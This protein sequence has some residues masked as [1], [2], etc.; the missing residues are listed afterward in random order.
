MTGSKILQQYKLN[1]DFKIKTKITGLYSTSKYIFDEL[2]THIYQNAYWELD[3]GYEAKLENITHCTK[4]IKHGLELVV[5]YHNMM[6]VTYPD[7]ANEFLN[8]KL[9]IDYEDRFLKREL[10][11]RDL[12]R[13]IINN[14]EIV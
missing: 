1:N 14:L 4:S 3:K 2:I 8:S 12:F 13:E 11:M 7:Y 6:I 9:F 10:I 5:K